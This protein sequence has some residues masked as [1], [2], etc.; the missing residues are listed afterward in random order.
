LQRNGIPITI[1]VVSSSRRDYCRQAAEGRLMSPDEFL[2]FA[3]VAF[4]NK[5]DITTFL[6]A[7][8]QGALMRGVINGQ[9][10]AVKVFDTDEDPLRVI[11]EVEALAQIDS[12]YLPKVVDA[13]QVRLPTGEDVPFVVY[14][15]LDGSDLT[16]LIG[17]S[18]DV[19][20]IKT[21]GLHVATAIDVLWRDRIVHRDIKP[22]NIM[23]VAGRYVL[24]DIGCAKHLDRTGVTLPN[25]RPGTKG[26]MSPEQAVGQ[27]LTSRSDIY[28]LGVALY[29][30][31]TGVHPFG[32]NQ[33]AIV[34]GA[35]PLLASQ[36]RPDLPDTL[37]RLLA[38]MLIARSPRRPRSVADEFAAL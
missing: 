30:I 18:P 10:V 29:E 21:V 34:R 16:G 22:A 23:T 5:I 6:K 7:G 2:A 9:D 13:G 38:R 1:G 26:Y 31:A 17:T 12:A 15:F 35:V 32:R 25:H 20:T 33:M 27:P 8:G 14:E 4:D 37:V 28:S 3:K 19:L 24:V 36:H 11:H